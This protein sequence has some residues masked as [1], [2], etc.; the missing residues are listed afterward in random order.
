MLKDVERLTRIKMEVD[1]LTVMRSCM[2]E[3]KKLSIKSYVAPLTK[4]MTWKTIT[5]TDILN[6]IINDEFFG[7]VKANVRTPLSVI[8]RLEHLNFPMIFRR[9]DGVTNFLEPVRCSVVH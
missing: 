1:E 4:F 3:K 2:W 6:A 8:E 7:L 9:V 5:E